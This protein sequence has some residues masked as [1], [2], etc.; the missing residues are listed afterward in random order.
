MHV[1]MTKSLLKLLPVRYLNSV[2]AFGLS[3]G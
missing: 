2:V 1:R 3:M